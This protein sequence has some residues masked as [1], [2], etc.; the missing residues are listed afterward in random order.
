MKFHEYQTAWE[1]IGNRCGQ[2]SDK[3][4]FYRLFACQAA[5]DNQVWTLASAAQDVAWYQASRPYYKVWPS[6]CKALSSLRLDVKYEQVPTV[7]SNVMV[8]RFAES[9]EPIENNKRLTSIMVSEWRAFRDA[10]RGLMISARTEG[11]IDDGIMFTIGQSDDM[12]I[13]ESLDIRATVTDMMNFEKRAARIALTVLLLADDPNIITPD[14]LSKDRD[15]YDRSTDEA[16]KE[17]AVERARR[18]GVVGWNIGADYEVCPHYRRPHF[19]L[20]HTGKGGTV[21]RIVPIKGAVVHRSRLTE[22]P[23][24]YMLPDGTEVEHGR[25]TKEPCCA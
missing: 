21:P 4:T 7:P 13:E 1:A 5:K 6:V 16:W 18:R 20:R 23:T 17:R 11:T 10:S 3:E 9:M 24:G 8:I 25:V 12:T 22:V 2:W 19:G 15:E 14:V